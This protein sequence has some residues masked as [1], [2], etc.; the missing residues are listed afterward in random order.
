MAKI[1]KMHHLTPVQEGMLFHSLLEPMGKHYF[2]QACF[3]IKGN[4][5]IELLKEAWQQMICRHEILRTDI[6]WKQIKAPVQVILDQKEVEIFTDDIS[7]L[8]EKEQ[9]EYICQLKEG[10]LYKLN[11]EKNKLN[12]LSLLKCSEEEVY[13]CWTF[14]H[15]LLDGWSVSI[16]LKDFLETYHTLATGLP[17]PA[18]PVA[19]FSTYLEWMKRQNK[20]KCSQFWENCVT[21][22]SEPTYLMKDNNEFGKD[23]LVKNVV[24]ELNE[25]QMK[26][27]NAFCKNNNITLNALVQTAWGILLQ[28]YNNTNISCSGITVSGR[29]VGIKN[30]DSI[31][32]ILI[33][34]LPVVIKTEKEDIVTELLSRVNTHLIEIQDYGYLSLPEIQKL[35]NL[36]LEQKFFDTLVAVENHPSSGIQLSNEEFSLEFDSGFEVT[37]YDFT[38]QAKG[39]KT[40]KLNVAHNLNRFTAT[41]ID[42]LLG[43]FTQI[44]L[45]MIASPAGFVKDITLLTEEEKRQILCEFNNTDV[46]Y[47]KEKTNQ[48]LVEE[49]VMLNPSHVAA[50]FKEQTLTYQE[51]NE[52]ANQLARKLRS[53]GVGPDQIV[54][55]MV[56]RSLEMVIG[57]LAVLKA[58][59]AY[60]P[61]DPDYPE[62]RIQFILTD[63]SPKIILTQN[64]LASKLTSFKGELIDLKD[65]KLYVGEKSNLENVNKSTD[66]A[67]I[68]YTS[69]STGKPKGTLIEHRGIVNLQKVFK[70]TLGITTEDKVVQFASFAFDASVW[71]MFMAYLTGATLYLVERDIIDNYTT[72]EKFINNNGITTMILP[73]FYLENLNPE[74]MPSLNK[75]MTGGSATNFKL[76]NR[77]KDTTDYF[78]AYGPTETTICASVWKYKQ[79][80]IVDEK[81]PIGKPIYNTKVYILDQYQNLVPVGVVGELCVSGDGLARGYLN[82]PELTG[83]KFINFNKNLMLLGERLYKTGDLARWL[84]DG[85]IEFMGRVDD[86]VK[87]RGYRIETGEIEVTLLSHPEVREAVVLAR[88][89]ESGQKYLCAYLIT[90]FEIADVRKYLATKLPEYMIP[91]HFIQLDKMPLTPNGKIDKKS[92]PVLDETVVCRAEYVAP[93]NEIEEKLVQIWSENFKIRQIGVTEN[94]FDLG[95]HSLIAIQIISR[96]LKELKVEIPLRK[97]F[98]LPT[99]RELA[100]YIQSGEENIY[101][102]IEP[103]AEQKYYSVS[104]AQKR[105]FAVKE[106]TGDTITYNIPLIWSIEGDLDR[107]K[108]EQAFTA[109]INRH[110]SLRTSFEIY[111]NQVMQKVHSHVYFT[112]HELEMGESGLDEIFKTFVRSFDLNRV[113]LFRVGLIKYKGQHLLIMDI[114]HIIADG[115]SMDILFKEIIQ[116]YEGNEL[117]P[118]KIQYKDY[119]NWQN[120]LF[121]SEQMRKQ[122]EYWSGVFKDEIPQLNLITDFQRPA[123]MSFKGDSVTFKIDETLTSKLQKLAVS[124]GVTMQMLLLGGL[125]VLLSKYSGQEDIVIGTPIANR[126]HPDLENLIGMFVNN[127]AIRNRPSGDKTFVQFLLEIKEKALTA[128]ENQ[129]YPFEML[130]DKLSLQRDMSRNPIFDVMFILQNTVDLEFKAGDVNFKPHQYDFKRAKFD[131]TLH[132]FEMDEGIRFDLVYSTSLYAAKSIERMAKHF[133]KILKEIVTSPELPLSALEMITANEKEQI[134]EHFNNTQVEYPTEKTITQL[135]EEQVEKSP[136][137]IAV[138]FAEKQCTYRELN[139]K[140]NQLARELR[141]KGVRPD[142]AVGIMLDRSIEMIV[143]VLAVVKAGGAYLPID[144]DYPVSR[145]EYMLKDAEVK[146]LLTKKEF[147]KQISFIGEVIDIED[148]QLYFNDSSNLENINKPEDLIYII[149]T[150]GSTGEPKGVMIEHCNVNR[151]ISNSNM[152]IINPKDR[153]LQTGSLAFDASTFEI[154]GSILNGASLYLLNKGDLMSSARLEERLKSYQITKMWLTAPLFNQ[155]WE[156]NPDIFSELKT[157]IVGGDILSVRHINAVRA[158][159][160]YLTIINGYGPTEGTTFTTYHKIERDYNSNIPIGKPVSNTRVYI[161]NQSGQLQPIGVPGELCITGDGLARGYL[162]RSELTYE[163]FISNPFN[164]TEKMY[165]TGDL[166]RWLDDGTLEFLGRIDQQV[167][168]RGFR[169]ELAEIEYYLAKYEEIKEVVVIDRKDASGSKI[170]LCIYCG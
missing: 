48:Q 29:P 87:I 127:L 170:S 34:T 149:Y 113:P 9:K 144:I 24:R 154:W 19:Q 69:G 28:R 103:V 83:D 112:V 6:L 26:E 92:L 93:T 135:F 21:D 118:L 115:V 8:N 75:I 147:I 46:E 40:L 31:V 90:D 65:E 122:E 85:N 123:K 109:L 78:N 140:A 43:N 156:E 108:L 11:L 68:I 106:L 167:K 14:H 116:L 16:L 10:N 44:L 120:Q 150:S 169:I 49:Q 84:P 94:I 133:V 13:M 74:R 146:N 86:Q 47:S 160:K 55:I 110:E 165:R 155:L 73:P 3:N 30:V 66:L 166:V 32:G 25:E 104:S 7:Q 72:F 80:E 76:V 91:S 23:L 164:A 77:W 96:I 138:V 131:L 97:I 58:G 126:S 79:D 63:S 61:I 141:N 100:K 152:L 35:S 59:G 4:F 129:D 50:V 136:D 121:E 52:R 124:N 54:V 38:L 163:K 70:E 64:D 130:V 27:I 17:L 71:E 2:E 60:L 132:A 98:E 51:L 36:N 5:K 162:N 128:Y 105:L 159:H 125:N 22:L 117:A 99:I 33:N 45:S 95:G 168:I 119:A 148:N 151:L 142:Q 101:T 157:L 111:N 143:A 18:G 53:K 153:I 67:Y 62:E 89:D 114:H 20:I 88:V 158:K 81:I 56:E 107:E 102:A 82:R 42:K 15:I 139:K 145:V 57:V 39:G 12:Y 134:V 161:F 137:N 37:N 41:F 1:L